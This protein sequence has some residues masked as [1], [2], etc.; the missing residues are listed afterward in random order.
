MLLAFTENPAYNRMQRDLI[1]YVYLLV[2]LCLFA[3]LCL[4]MLWI[5][6]RFPFNTLK[7]EFHLSKYKNSV[8]MRQEAHCV[9]IT[10]TNHLMRIR[11]TIGLF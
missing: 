7:H 2:Y 5:P 6:I 3:F 1:V 10:K 4:F 11:I 8:P 9:S